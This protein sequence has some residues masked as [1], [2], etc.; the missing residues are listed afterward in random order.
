MHINS[1]DKLQNR[2]NKE[3]ILKVARERRHVTLKKWTA[4]TVVANFSITKTEAGK[5]WNY[6]FRILRKINYQTRIE[7]PAKL[8]F[9]NDDKIEILLDKTKTIVYHLQQKTLRYSLK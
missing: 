1:T 9:N 3:N 8:S 6:I 2:N 4:N 5:N 7:Y